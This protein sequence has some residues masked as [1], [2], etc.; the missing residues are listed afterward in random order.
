[1]DSGRDMG[2]GAK[3]EGAV[4]NHQVVRGETDRFRRVVLT[5]KRYLTQVFKTADSENTI[6]VSWE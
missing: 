1:M 6:F 5:C 4:T 3:G 2:C